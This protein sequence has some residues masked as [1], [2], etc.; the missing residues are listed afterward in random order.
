MVIVICSTR[1]FETTSVQAATL[2]AGGL[3]LALAILSL[4]GDERKRHVPLLVS[5]RSARLMARLSAHPLALEAMAR[6]GV[7]E[8]IVNVREVITCSLAWFILLYH[9]AAVGVP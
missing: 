2:C 8:R 6:P 4:E 5:A 3:T 1:T 9:V 7:I